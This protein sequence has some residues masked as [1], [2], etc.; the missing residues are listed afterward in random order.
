MN[1]RDEFLIMFTILVKPIIKIR[2]LP[3]CNT[4]RRFW[5][6]QIRSVNRLMRMILI[7]IR[8]VVSFPLSE[9]LLRI[10]NVVIADLPLQHVQALF[11][12]L[13]A[14][15]YP[16]IFSYLAYSF[17]LLFSTYFRFHRNGLG[18]F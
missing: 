7:N 12:P 9:P 3:I 18:S 6:L 2:S 8:L 1:Y 14:L 10:L 11:L 16:A 15:V 17:Q 5:K 13:F 4:V